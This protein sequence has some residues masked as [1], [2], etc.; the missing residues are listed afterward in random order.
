[1]P[2]IQTI[3][4]LIAS[5]TDLAKALIYLVIVTPA[6]LNKAIENIPIIQK[7]SKRLLLKAYLKYERGDYK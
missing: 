7:N 2:T 6:I 3:I 4:V 1:M 5:A